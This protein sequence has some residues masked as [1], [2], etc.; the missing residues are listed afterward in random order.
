MKTIPISARATAMVALLAGTLAL[1]AC[2]DVTSTDD[3]TARPQ[4]D[5]VREQ[6]AGAGAGA[7]SANDQALRLQRI[8]SSYPTAGLEVPP[9]SLTAQPRATQAPTSVSA[10]HPSVTTLRKAE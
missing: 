9:A 1:G 10:P 2:G 7:V 3:V 8:R 6:A 4:A 5:V